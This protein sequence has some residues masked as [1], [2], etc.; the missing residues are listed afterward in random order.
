MV[1]RQTSPT[2]P[3]SPLTDVRERALFLQ[4]ISPNE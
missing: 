2:S 4:M 1:A 3:T